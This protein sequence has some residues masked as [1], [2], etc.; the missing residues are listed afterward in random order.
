MYDHLIAKGISA[1]RISH[2]GFGS[3]KPAYSNRT[4]DGRAAN[5]RIE[6]KVISKK[7]E[8]M[9][10]LVDETPAPPEDSFEKH[11]NSS[12]VDFE[13]KEIGEAL[14][15]KH[16]MFEPN[17]TELTEASKLQADT[18][19]DI[20]KANSDLIIEV[21]GYTDK[22]GIEEKNVVLSKN[23]AKALHDYLIENGIEAERL[24]YSGCGSGNPIA[25]NKYRW[26]RDINRRIEVVIIKK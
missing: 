16:V 8:S 9:T 6:V 25:P 12:L 22:S 26:G 15:L 13:K 21:F 10:N 1:D 7:A 14:I 3:A 24:F 20:L 2:I 17:M 23:R 11:T 19:V 18:L 5:R 4:K